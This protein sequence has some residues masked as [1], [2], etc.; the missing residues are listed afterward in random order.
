MGLIAYNVLADEVWRRLNDAADSTDH[1]MRVFVLATT[2]ADGAPDARLMVLRGADRRTGRIWFHTDRRSDKVEHVRRHPGVCAVAWDHRSGVQVRLR[3]AAAVHEDDP[4][5]TR[6]WEQ[7]NAATRALYAS[8]DVPGAPLRQ[9]DPRLM[10]L[11]H[12]LDA[13]TE[14]AARANFAV[15]EVAMRTIEWLQVLDDSQRRA[16]LHAATSW[17]VQPVAP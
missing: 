2:G 14:A 10:C 12:A 11:R 6:H 1:P 17:A 3:G 13:G 7:I 15:I 4:V 9:P 8:P 16:V 5:A